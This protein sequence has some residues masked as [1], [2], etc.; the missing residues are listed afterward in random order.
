MVVAPPDQQQGEPAAGAQEVGGEGEEGAVERQEGGFRQT[1]GAGPVQGEVEGSGE[2]GE[3]VEAFVAHMKA[4][5]AELAPHRGE[6][7]FAEILGD[8]CP[9]AGRRQAAVQVDE[10]V[11]GRRLD[12]GSAAARGEDAG[13]GGHRGLDAGVDQHG[14]GDDAIDG[15]GA[16]GELLGG[17]GDE[18]DAPGEAEAI[19]EA[20]GFAQ[21]GN[22]EVGDD[23]AGAAA[24]KEG[25]DK[26]EAAADVDGPA[27]VE[28]G[29]VA[30]SAADVGGVGKVDQ[31]LGRGAGGAIGAEVLGVE[32]GLPVGTVHPP[33]G[34]GL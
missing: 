31:H 24:G 16:E 3:E 20:A 6:A 25:G 5:G 29:E 34:G 23:D 22:A 8:F 18:A 28:R 13:D 33:A 19:E 14:F 26:T 15:G 2:E 27:A 32:R 10:G 12:D 4:G 21:A 9:D 11:A 17:A 30:E 7:G 1:V